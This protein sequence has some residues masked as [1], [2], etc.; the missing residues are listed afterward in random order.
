MKLAVY[1][2][3]RA[4]DVVFALLCGVKLRL[5]APLLLELVDEVRRVLDNRRLPETWDRLLTALERALRSGVAIDDSTLEM[6]FAEAGLSD[7]YP[8]ILLQ[9][10]QRPLSPD[11]A[12]IQGLAQAYV[13][14]LQW[15]EA[16]AFAHMLAQSIDSLDFE[17]AGD[18]LVFESMRLQEQIGELRGGEK[19]ASVD[20]SS[21]QPRPREWVIESLIPAKFTTIFYGQ[22]GSAK[23]YLSLA[24]ALAVITGKPFL[25]LPVYKRGDVL[26]LDLEMDGEENA[27]RWWAICR[28][29]GYESPPKGLHYLR[30]TRPV[31]IEEPTIRREIER[32]KPALVIVDSVARATGKPT[33]HDLAS[34]LFQWFDTLGCPVLAIDHEPRPRPDVPPEQRG[35][36]GTSMKRNAARSSLQIEVESSESS[37]LHLI[38]RQQ[39]ISFAGRLQE[40][41]IALEFEGDPQFT[42]AV[43]ISLSAPQGERG[44]VMEYL[45]TVGEAGATIA[46]IV[47]ALGLEEKEQHKVRRAIK[48]LERAK[49]VERVPQSYPHRYRLIQPPPP[50]TE[51]DCQ[52]DSLTPLKEC[53]SVKLPESATRG[54]GDASHHAGARGDGDAAFDGAEPQFD[55]FT[56]LLRS[57]TVKLPDALDESIEAL[58]QRWASDALFPAEPEELATARALWREAQRRGFPRLA[59]PGYAV[60]DAGVESW[61]AAFE[62]IAITPAA[63]QALAAL[64]EVVS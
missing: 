33:D 18:L 31:F 36:F 62:H 60:V 58:L 42:R 55:S 14:A 29:A 2:E 20:L 52:F 25:S 23:S 51:P 12:R 40:L 50:P 7:S 28:G 59:V 6:I 13:R 24:V 49:L 30:L 19:A 21:I 3:E 10:Q 16:R 11:R 34:N 27:L 9:L 5:G 35:E 22:A 61:R 17:R 8:E 48:S 26:L 15:K 38:L 47:D 64:R 56:P 4:R 44:E 45:R 57:Q 43:R 41:H 1:I 39:K 37:R 46:Q 54:E 53:K 63:Q 32:I